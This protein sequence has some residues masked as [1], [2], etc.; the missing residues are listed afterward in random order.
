MTPEE[1]QKGFQ[2]I[3]TSLAKYQS[4]MS[5]KDYETTPLFHHP[6]DKSYKGCI[7]FVGFS[8][9]SIYPFFHHICH[10]KSHIL[11]DDT[12]LIFWLVQF[13]DNPRNH[14]IWAEARSKYWSYIT[15]GLTDCSG[16]GGAAYRDTKL[17]F[18][19]LAELYNAKIIEKEVSWELGLAAE[20]QASQTKMATEEEMA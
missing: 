14:Q 19:F 12:E 6:F 20:R 7:D 11:T 17:V 9:D 18:Q 5:D 2:L 15:M 8:S 16:S 4:W 3:A 10:P 13:N 1:K